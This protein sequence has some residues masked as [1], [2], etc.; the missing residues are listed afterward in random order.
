MSSVNEE[1]KADDNL[2][3]SENEKET[4]EFDDNFDNFNDNNDDE[5]D[6]NFVDA[7]NNSDDE[8]G[9]FDDFEE[10]QVPEFEIQPKAPTEAELYVR[11]RKNN[12]VFIFI[13]SILV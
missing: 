13:S 1:L 9:D 2:N 10:S 6:D 11:Q 8:F 3:F 12:R 7:G 5:F 4:D